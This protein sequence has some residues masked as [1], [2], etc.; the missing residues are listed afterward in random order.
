MHRLFPGILGEVEEMSSGKEHEKGCPFQSLRA[1][2]LPGRVCAEDTEP[3]WMLA[4]C[5][6]FKVKG[7]HQRGHI[8][9]CAHW[10][11]ECPD[12]KPGS[13]TYEHCNFG[14]SYLMPR[15]L[16]FPADEME[17]SSTYLRGSFKT[18]RDK[19]AKML[20]RCQHS[21]ASVTTTAAE[22]RLRSRAG[23]LST[24]LILF[25]PQLSQR[26]VGNNARPACSA[27]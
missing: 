19:G 23:R 1:I 24:T 8:Q 7:F 2:S 6:R 21:R 26:H 10:G 5:G 14:K 20:R 11:T 16:S 15:S 4:T 25:A 9:C 3:C 18:L 17:D 27:T 22:K 13:V 12:L